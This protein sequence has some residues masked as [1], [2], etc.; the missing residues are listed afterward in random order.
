MKRIGLFVVSALLLTLSAG[1]MGIEE[2]HRMQGKN[3]DL[4]FT[5]Y[6]SP[7]P[8]AKKMRVLIFTSYRSGS[9]RY[10]QELA[11]RFD[12]EH[13]I[14]LVHAGKLVGAN[15]GATRL[16]DY[17]NTKWDAFVFLQDTPT[18]LLKKDY[19][20][21]Y[22]M[23]LVQIVREG[24]GLVMADYED[25]AV[26]KEKNFLPDFKARSA[27]PLKAKYYRIGKG[28]GVQLQGFDMPS[29]KHRKRYGYS[30]RSDAQ[31]LPYSEDWKNEY[32]NRFRILGEQL[33]TVTRKIPEA[34]TLTRKGNTLSLKGKF[35]PGS[36]LC[37]TVKGFGDTHKIYNGKAVSRNFTLPALPPGKY[38]LTALVRKDGKAV[39]FAGRTFEIR[40]NKAN[41]ITS[42]TFKDYANDV[43][44]LISGKVNSVGGGKLIMRL[45]DTQR[46]I[47]MQ[48]NLPADGSFSFKVE[49]WMP[50]MMTLEAS[51]MK[52]NKEVSRKYDY[53]N[54]II[55]RWD[56]FEFS[57]WGHAY[58]HM[59]VHNLNYRLA[60]EGMTSLMMP[61][62]T[63]KHSP[64]GLQPYPIHSA[65]V[66]DGIPGKSPKECFFSDARRKRLTDRFKS[67]GPEFKVGMRIVSLGDEVQEHYGCMAPGCLKEYRNFLNRKYKG[68]LA[69]LNKNWGTKYKSWDQ[70]TVSNIPEKNNGKDLEKYMK[71]FA[72]DMYRM[73]FMHLRPHYVNW[74]KKSKVPIPK[75]ISLISVSWKADPRA[76]RFWQNMFIDQEAGSFLA[77]NYARWID[78]Q[79]FKSYAYSETNRFLRDYFRKIDP[80]TLAGME[81]SGSIDLLSHGDRQPATQGWMGNYQENNHNN[82]MNEVTRSITPN[83]YISNSW[84]GYTPSPSML[85]DRVW[86]ELFRRPAMIMFYT[87]TG[88]GMP[89]YQGILRADLSLFP[90]AGEM[91]RQ[92]KK[93][94]QGLGTSMIRSISI[95]DP[96]AILYSYPSSVFGARVRGGDSFD[97]GRLSHNAAIYMA[98]NMGYSFRYVTVD[99][100]MNGKDSLKDFKVLIL[101]H[102]SALSDEM[103]EKLEEF[104]REGGSVIA[105]I[106]T[107]IMDEHLIVR[108][109]NP[110]E[111]VAGIKRNAITPAKSMLLTPSFTAGVKS[112]MDAGVALGTGTARAAAADGTPGWII[113]KYGKGQVLT[114]N[115]PFQDMGGVENLP[116]GYKAILEDA[117]KVVGK[118]PEV[119]LAGKK[120]YDIRRG[121]WQNGDMR[122]LGFKGRPGAKKTLQVT[123]PKARYVYSIDREKDLGKVKTFAV[124]IAPPKPEFFVV[125]S[126]PLPPVT[127]KVPAKVKMGST[128]AVTFQVKGMKGE[129][130]V[131]IVF[132]RDG[133][134][135]D[136]QTIRESSCKGSGA[137]RELF[138]VALNEKPGKYAIRFTDIYTGKTSIH[139]IAIV[140]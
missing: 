140:K 65:H 67:H 62:Y 113:H 5:P 29:P 36:Q 38:F 10:A 98:L 124:P 104:V 43:G 71:V 15:S 16:E 54:R 68:D 135:I 137:V 58:N 105:D 27:A 108:K 72:G 64:W 123:L 106:R 131:R 49:S 66:F 48:K 52:G 24:A 19:P 94:R 32:D 45:R 55:R 61:G 47:L 9:G 82:L 119:K 139:P 12:L 76:K 126:K 121:E 6:L 83:N 18:G 102:T 30:R 11:N 103:L 2:P 122:I 133:K 74:L 40:E 92:T 93:L 79:D 91:L 14:V 77:G 118:V 87:T 7:A 26:L 120:V 8:F 111:K 3:L 34:L 117:F 41:C 73:N 95:N 101:P 116:A 50:S 33:L 100:L 114:L 127:V 84:V 132:E 46:R 110:W 107:G 39:N 69:R 70:V 1:L 28:L 56:M 25:P 130:P 23:M 35:A 20:K 44:K 88:D 21:L 4:S 31:V 109:N 57:A 22:A 97:Y 78:R 89:S 85:C 42:I 59:G 51:L 75:A 81:G 17:L 37:L 60:E 129:R 134:K 136:L 63:M 86:N 53:C 99:R 125:T 128:F 96:V 138:R 115:F 13:G 80:Y 112:Q 90:A